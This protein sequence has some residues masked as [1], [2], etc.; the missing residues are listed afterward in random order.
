[1]TPRASEFARPNF[2]H[3]KKILFANV[4]SPGFVYAIQGP[5]GKQR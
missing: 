2:S 5:F 1:V 3:D 4:Q